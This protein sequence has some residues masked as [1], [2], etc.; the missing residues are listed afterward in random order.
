MAKLRPEMGG[1]M[2]GDEGDRPSG[3]LLCQDVLNTFTGASPINPAGWTRLPGDEVGFANSFSDRLAMIC[4]PWPSGCETF[5][6]VRALPH[7]YEL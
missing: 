2:P 1:W 4:A 3:P 6:R 7:V 5:S